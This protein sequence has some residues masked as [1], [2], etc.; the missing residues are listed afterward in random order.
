[1][2]LY[3]FYIYT[4]SG[5]S[6]ILLCCIMIVKQFKIYTKTEIGAYF[7]SVFRSTM[8][9]FDTIQSGELPLLSIHNVNFFSS[10]RYNFVVKMKLLHV[11]LPKFLKQ[12]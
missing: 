9:I 2:S 12:Q 7:S 8:T 4:F 11:P 3:L 10:P 1:M 6:P 5:A